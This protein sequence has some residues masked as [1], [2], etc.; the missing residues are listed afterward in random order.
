MAHPLRKRLPAPL[1]VAEPSGPDAMVGR[2]ALLTATALAALTAAPAAHA[3]DGDSAGRPNIDDMELAPHSV[4]FGEGSGWGAAITAAQG[5]PANFAVQV[6]GEASEKL[7][8]SNSEADQ[9]VRDEDGD[10]DEWVTVDLASIQVDLRA[11]TV[12]VI[13]DISPGTRTGSLDPF[14]DEREIVLM[15]GSLDPFAGSIDPFAGSI[16]P[17]GGSLDPFGGSIDPFEGSI[18][19]FSGSIDPFGGSINPFHGEIRALWGAI[20]PFQATGIGDGIVSPFQRDLNPY[21]RATDEASGVRLPNYVQVSRFWDR[22]GRTW[23]G[24]NR[25]INNIH[26][27]GAHERRSADLLRKIGVLRVQTKLVWAEAIE[28]RTGQSFDEAFIDPLYEKFGIG[29]D[30]EAG[31]LALTPGQRARLVT[32]WFDT[33]MTYTGSDHIDHWMRTINWNPELTRVQGSGRDAVIGILDSSIVNGNEFNGNVIQSGGY[34][35]KVGGHGVGVASLLIGAHDGKGTFGI[36]PNASVATYNPFDETGS[37][38]WSDVVHGIRALKRANASV[39]N[40]SLGVPNWTLHP[41][42]NNVF[43]RHLTKDVAGDTVFVLAAGNDGVTQRHNIEWHLN[44]R[45][46]IIVVGAID[47]L[48]NISDISNRPGSVCFT[49]AGVCREGKNTRLRDYFIVAPGEHILVSDGEGGLIRRSGT[50]FAAPLVSGAITLL[51]DRWPWLAQHPTA[52]VDIILGTAKDLGEPGTDDVFG[53]GLLDVEAA[54]SPIIFDNLEIFE[55]KG[56]QKKQYKVDDL[57]ND[58]G[59]GTTWEADGVFLTMFERLSDTQRDFLVPFSNSL[60]GQQSGVNGSSE[61]FQNYVRQR[62]TDWRKK[63]KGR[64]RKNGFTDLAHFDTPARD[65]L[66]LS[67]TASSPAAFL[68][69]RH[70]G[71]VPH[72]AIRI[73]DGEGQFALNAGHGHGAVSLL[74]QGGFG[75]TTDYH[76]SSGGLNPVL[77][78]ASGGAFIDAEYKIGKRTTI[79]FGTTDR[80]LDH[81]ENPDLTAAERARLIATPDYRANAFNLRVTH[82][83]SRNAA[84]TFSVAQLNERDALLGVQSELPGALGEGST[85]RTLTLGGSVDLPHGITMAASATAG[86]SETDGADR[87]LRSNGAVASSAFA[88]SLAKEGIVGSSDRLRISVAQ[89]LHIESGSMTFDSFEVIDRSTGETGVVVREFDLATRKRRLTGEFLYAAPVMDGGEISFFGR[90][91]HDPANAGGV[92]QIVAGGRL[93]LPF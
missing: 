60:V 84:L 4:R 53:R 38:N 92:N 77:A 50:S 90:L 13:G 62:F 71:D 26:E 6:L 52:T 65:G 39:I 43:N 5:L 1:P 51:H 86:L 70:G 61:Y 35:A 29:E 11:A 89:P 74:G 57:L 3:A 87:S 40:M 22:F 42:W 20:D 18:D 32:E 12:D 7:D 93:S 48:G 79:A 15:A 59:I 91:E 82:K 78:L 30:K 80:T 24:L 14:G 49:K 21:A 69:S 19:P 41:A 36:A 76:A 67:L 23:A 25:Q 2:S 10:Q 33:L 54:Q 75:L 27:H 72:S 64:G 46:G 34:D 44:Q 55:F 31:F 58:D 85:S 45:F 16:D 66:N 81:S 37:A 88:F 73:A 56:G 17:F 83:P 9:E 68:A 63:R 28:G 8:Q 47:A